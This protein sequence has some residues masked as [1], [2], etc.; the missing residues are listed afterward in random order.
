MHQQAEQLA[1]TKTWRCCR[2]RRG[3]AKSARWSGSGRWPRACN[4]QTQ[5]RHEQVDAVNVGEWV[6]STACSA[7]GFRSLFTAHHQTVRTRHAKQRLMTLPRIS[8][9]FLTNLP[10]MPGILAISARSAL[11]ASRRT[12]TSDR[13]PGETEH[14]QSILREVNSHLV[15]TFFGCRLST[16]TALRYA[17]CRHLSPVAVKICSSRSKGLVRCS[18]RLTTEEDVIWQARCCLPRSTH[19]L[20]GC[21]TA[22][23]TCRDTNQPRQTQ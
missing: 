17:Y 19:A 16:P 11:H 5:T 21:R 3:T 1:L 23:G 6:R 18:L 4:H 10:P 9:I 8:A 7:A 14:K 2:R 12:A 15:W 20:S 13:S 22:E